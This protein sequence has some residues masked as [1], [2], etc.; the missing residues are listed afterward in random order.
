MTQ[1]LGHLK[2]RCAGCE[3]HD[4]PM[5]KEHVF[6]QWLIRKTGTHLTGIRWGA[7]PDV[8]ALAVTLPLCTECNADF[9]RELEAPTVQVFDDIE[10]GRG[11]SDGEAELLI[12]WMWKIMGLAWIACNPGHRYTS[13]YTLRERVPLPIDNLRSRLILAVA[14]IAGPHP[15]SK[16][17]PMGLDSATLQDATFVSGVFSRIAMMSVLEPLEDLIPDQFGRYLLAGKRNRLYAGKFFYPPTSFRD[18]VE[19]VQVTQLAS[20]RLSLAHDE[21]ALRV[22]AEAS[23]SGRNRR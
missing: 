11:L 18:D 1:G 9:G 3:R 21:L 2:D 20:V 12:R 17:L 14:V 19:A 23:L 5:N 22:Q 4:V 7:K 8:S 16:D 10:E 15:D 6:P 13:K